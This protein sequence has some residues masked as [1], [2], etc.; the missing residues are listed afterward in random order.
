M[1]DIGQMPNLKLAAQALE[2]ALAEQEYGTTI[3]FD[4]LNEM[5][6]LDVRQY[7]SVLEAVK[8]SLMRHHNRVLI[9]LRGRGYQIA[10]QNQYRTVASS[11]RKNAGLA[12]LARPNSVPVVGENNVSYL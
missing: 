12:L 3:S 11:Y 10:Q 4:E 2:Q 8:R 9:N 5:A 6:G 1:V 7:R